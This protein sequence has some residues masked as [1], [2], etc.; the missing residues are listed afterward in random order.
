MKDYKLSRFKKLIRISKKNHRWLAKNKGEYKTL[1]GTLDAII[2]E[3]KR[4]SILPVS[5][6]AKKRK[7]PCKAK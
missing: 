2:N 5:K 7:L 3:S 1:A 6:R 4:N